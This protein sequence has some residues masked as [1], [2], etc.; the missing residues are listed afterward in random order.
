MT[1]KLT[2]ESIEN[3][4]FKLYTPPFVYRQGYIFDSKNEVVA[5]NHDCV[6]DQY[7]RLGPPVSESQPSVRVRG[8]GRISK[9]EDADKIS[10]A[11]GEH[12]AKALTE[13]WQ[14]H[15]ND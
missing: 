9:M 5:D 6:S 2:S 3:R 7:A 10:D 15:A 14:N 8:W 4:A 13:Y 1:D 12:I 11:A